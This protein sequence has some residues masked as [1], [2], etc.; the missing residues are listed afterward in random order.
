MTDISVVGAGPAGLKTVLELLK[1]GYDGE[2]ILFEEHK[3]IGRPVHCS[4]VVSLK[5]LKSFYLK[6]MSNKYIQNCVSGAKIFFP[7]GKSLFVKADKNVA[8]IIDRGLFDLS[9]YY[10]VID[11]GIP[12]RKENKVVDIGIKN[13]KFRILVRDRSKGSIS[14]ESEKV[15]LA[16]GVNDILS[17]KMGFGKNEKVIPSLQYEVEGVKDL[18][19][20]VVEIYIGSR[21]SRGLFAWII[22]LGDNMARIGLADLVNPLERLRYFIGKDPLVSSRITNLKIK[23]VLGGA[24]ITSGPKKE[25]YKTFERPIFLIGDS[26]GQ[27]KPTTGGGIVLI[28]KAAELLSE[29]IISEKYGSYQKKWWQEMGNEIS[30]QLFLRKFLDSLSDKELVDIFDI[31]KRGGFEEISVKIG[32]MDFQ[33]KIIKKFGIKS[34]YLF[35]KHPRILSKLFT[36]FI[37]TLFI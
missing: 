32:E 10:K 24:V 25:L 28:G 5:G 29:S 21:Y 15:I 33:S 19:E 17:Q 8:A 3:E 1:R 18:D 35:L 37:K 34:F 22:P 6:E 7:N 2:I 14:Y 12:V 16:T 11:K 20:D 9:L 27:T 36:V 26:A 4:G 23:S 13:N 30:I 31:L